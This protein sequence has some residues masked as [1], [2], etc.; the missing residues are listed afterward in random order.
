VIDVEAARAGLATTLFERLAARDSDVVRLLTVQHR[1]HATIM[2]FPSA[3]KYDGRLVAAPAVA[4]H[5]LEDLGVAAD[6]LRPGPLVFVDSAGKG[7][8]EERAAEDASTSNPRQAERTAAEA[9]RLLARGVAPTDLA[10]ITPYDAQARLLRDL[11]AAEHAAGVEI[12]SI[13]GFQGREKEAVIVDLVRSNDDGAIGFLADTRRMNVALT[14]ARRF[15]L[16]IGDSAT[17]GGSSYYAAFLATVE[18]LGAYVSAWA[19]DAP[20]P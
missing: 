20:L 5:T 4:T 13:D 11:L 12:G 15:L 6:P 14:R 7:W 10:V 19:D 16:V 3:S 18:R 2:A 17:L 8:T 9:R 1:M